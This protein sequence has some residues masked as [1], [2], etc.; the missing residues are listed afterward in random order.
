M[1]EAIET[2]RSCCGI[3][4]VVSVDGR[5]QYD[6]LPEGGGRY[7]VRLLG[8]GPWT[9]EVRHATIEPIDIAIRDRVIG[10]TDPVLTREV[11]LRPVIR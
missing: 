7:L 11:V 10:P 1:D 4:A 3:E 2:E 8:R 5:G 6:W 9:V